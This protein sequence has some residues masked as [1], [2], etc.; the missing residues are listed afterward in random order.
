MSAP[1]IDLLYSS[2]SIG[3]RIHHLRA[4]LERYSHAY[5][6]LDELLIPDVDYDIM[7]KTLEALEE[8]N[9]D[10]FDANSITQRVGG[11]GQSTFTPVKHLRPMLSLANAMIDEELTDFSTQVAKGL[12]ASEDNVEFAVEPKF[13]GLAMSLLYKNGVLTC[14]T[15][16]GDGETGED[17]TANIRTIRTIPQ[18]LRPAC[19]ALGIDIPEL[20]EVRGEV[21]MMRKDFEA[22]NTKARQNGTKV[23][24]NPRNAAA[25]SLRQQDSKV[26]AQRALSF[27]AY[28]LGEAKG[29]DMGLSHTQSME[30]I[31]ALGFPVSDLSDCVVGLSG[32]R[33]YYNRI[34]KARDGLDFDID[35]VVYK[36]NQYKLQ[37]D[38]G[39]R[40]RTPKWAVAHKF[41][42]L[43]AMTICKDIEIQVGRTGAQTPVAR[44]EPVLVAGVMVS[45]ATLHNIDEIHRKDIRV[46]DTVIVRRAGDVIPEVVS[47]V[48]D[49]RPENTIPFAMPSCC[50]SCDGKIV[51]PPGEAVYRCIAGFDCEAQRKGGLE[52]FVGRRAMDIDGLGDTHLSNAVEQGFIHDPADLYEWGM[53]VQNWCKLD[54]M[55][56]KLATRIVNNIEASK[57]RPLAR[58]V[59]AL[60]IRQV[61]ETTA[62]DLAKHFGSFDRILNATEEDLLAIDGVGPTVAKALADWY[63]DP[64]NQEMIDRMKQAG[65]NPEVPSQPLNSEQA[66]FAGKTIV[67]TGTLPTLSRDEAKAHIEALGG[68]VSSSVSKK[69]DF[70]LAGE[71]AGSKLKKAEELGVLVMDEAEFL[72]LLQGPTPTPAVRR[73]RP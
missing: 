35:G 57:T 20:L 45:N 49:R 63:Q 43:E 28:A 12:H 71:E 34:Q 30:K 41:P 26:T 53:S 56:E 18:D 48:V 58:V 62:K 27:F 23:L 7:F 13:D 15:T 68:K 33:D 38:L 67:L 50:P 14:G 39:F 32:L 36:V 73:P 21:L 6:V 55:G 60:G 72:A 54:R 4:D 70:V 1:S 25:G 47:S 29:I 40:S 11:A 5:H 59:Y 24:A 37:K 44:L 19:K 64:R 42:A 61:G 3:D 8:E 9:P 69:T 17:V 65:L 16:R 31:K 52:L 22:Y 66:I 10:F 51:R 2:L 46:G